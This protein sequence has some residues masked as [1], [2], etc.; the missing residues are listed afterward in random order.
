M[1]IEIRKEKESEYP[2]TEKM[3]R[4]SFWNKYKPGCNEHFMVHV[5]RNHE[6]WLPELSRIAVVDGEIAGVIMYFESQITQAD[7]TTV[8]VASFGPLCVS[9]KFRAMGV[10]MKLMKETLPLA[11][12]AGYPGVLII[13]EPDYYPRAGFIQCKDRGITDGEG[14]SWSAYMVYEFEEGSMQIPG[15]MEEPYDITEGIPPVPPADYESQ[16]AKWNRAVL[17][18]QFDYPAPCD[19]NNGYHLVREEENP[20]GFDEIFSRADGECGAAGENAAAVRREVMNHGYLIR[21]GDDTIGVC[22]IS[23]AE[24]KPAVTHLWLEESFKG[25]GI[26]D[27]IVA[28]LAKQN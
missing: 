28:T 9:H 4:E 14:N 2:A 20:K 1:E 26:E 21:K 27:D 8:K 19:D 5:M 12:A 13:G 15:I 11:K 16:F 23:T 24:E 18:C 6:A 7:G 17:P 25:K 10:G 22:V 3:V